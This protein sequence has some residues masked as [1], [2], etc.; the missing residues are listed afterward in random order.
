MSSK[1]ESCNREN[2]I[3][4]M[5]TFEKDRWKITQKSNGDDSERQKNLRKSSDQMARPRKNVLRK[6]IAGKMN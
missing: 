2:E 1:T 3:K 6:V 5:W 4:V